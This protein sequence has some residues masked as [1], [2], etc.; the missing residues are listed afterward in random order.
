[1]TEKPLDKYIKSPPPADER[2]HFN[3]IEEQL[4]RLENVSNSHVV[5]IEDN[6]EAA[7]ALVQQEFISRVNGDEALAQYVLTVAAETYGQASALV[8]Q[9]VTARTTADSALASNITTLQANVGTLS[10]SITNEA[11]IRLTADEA[12]G[13]RIDNLVLTSGNNA[14]VIIDEEAQA[15]IT[16][17]VALG[18]RIDSVTA[19]MNANTAAISTEQ[20]TRATRDDALAQQLFTMSSGSSRVYINATAPGSTGR[21]PGD[22]WFDSDDNYRPYVWARSTPTATT[23]SYDWRDNS[24]GTF[25]NNV[26]NYAVYTQAISTLTNTTTSQASS[27]TALQTTVGNS[28]SGLVRDVTA[29]STAVGDSSSGLVRDVSTLQSTTAQQRIF[30]QATPPSTSTADRKIGDLWFDTSNGN[31]PYYW[32]G[33]GWV[34]NT[35]TTRASQAALTTEQQ[36]RTTADTALASFL[37]SAS[38]GTSRV[39][40]SN[41]GITGRQT[42]DVWIRPDENF[43]QYVWAQVNDTG[44]FDWRD[45]SS[46]T[47]TRYIGILANVTNTSN[48][49]F[50][51]ASSAQ[52]T[53]A[54]AN[55]IAQQATSTANSASN[56]ANN[57]SS[58][59]SIAQGIANT[60][61]NVANSANSTANAAATTAN[62]ANAT[63]IS[64]ANQV[65]ALSSTISDGLNSA[66]SR[67]DTVS[68]TVATNNTALNTRIDNLTTTVNNNNNSLSSTISN[69]QTTATNDRN[70]FAGQ[71]SSLQSVVGSGP[72]GGVSLTQALSTTASTA[73]TANNNATSALNTV[74]AAVTTANNLSYEWRVQGT[75]DG[76]S[77]G[78]RLAGAK[79][80]NPNTGQ[81]ENTANLVID[82]DTTINGALLVNG[83]I[84]NPKIANN[85]VSNQSFSSSINTGTTSVNVNVRPGAKVQIV[86]NYG[87]VDSSANIDKV[88]VVK[89]WTLT[90]NNS[91]SAPSYTA[92]VP[93]L[94]ALFKIDSQIGSQTASNVT[95]TPVIGFNLVSA[96]DDATSTPVTVNGVTFTN[97]NRVWE[98]YVLGTTAVGY[99]TNNTASEQTVTFRAYLDYRN[100]SS[101]AS[102]S[103]PITINV[104]ELAK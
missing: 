5:R 95:L 32:N 67:I 59:A 76:V 82:A 78:L 18:V 62:S 72:G 81:V 58:V 16:A 48:S 30:R 7:K 94:A 49:A 101:A 100:E 89:A 2:S 36:A 97:Y 8:Q 77:G 60:A 13:T 44:P 31:T 55:T 41:P 90:S 64:A 11:S 83:T 88:Q 51:T 47:Y 22:V 71:I 39:Y 35:D 40:T 25:T 45:N 34:L 74:N 24:T 42:G 37:M 104:I 17:D 91:T 85:A 102:G 28:S 69:I 52:S 86:A 12:L 43:R 56:T 92:P 14:A 99:Y 73:N 84:S 57:A 15:R 93:F 61:Q 70:T 98:W 65:N 63:A 66:N 68:A 54:A 53:A 33:S 75:I 9:E 79:R 87:A 19:T 23:G 80:V 96:R 27:I 10:G 1:M 38:A 103:R 3:Y 29:L 50:T 4:T 46:G 20:T 6:N 21:Q 26:G